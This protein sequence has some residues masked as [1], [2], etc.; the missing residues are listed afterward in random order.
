MLP[1]SRDGLPHFKKRKYMN[2][3][4]NDKSKAEYERM[5]FLEKLYL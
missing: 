3:N 1:S 2:W 4:K 5:D